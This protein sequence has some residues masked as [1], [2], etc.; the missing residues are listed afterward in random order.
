M[1]R[2]RN[3]QPF[4]PLEVPAVG[5]GTIS[6]PDDLAGSYG[7]VTVQSNA[8]LKLAGGVY[9]FASLAVGTNSHVLA[10]A[11]TQLL[12]G[13]SVSVGSN[14]S[15]APT[16]AGLSAN[17]P[18]LSASMSAMSAGCAALR[19]PAAAMPRPMLPNRVRAGPHSG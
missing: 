12:V 10:L 6:L 5:G 19:T 15:L 13:G 4:P 3:G 14:A 2:L 7:V 8:T 18:S 1:S 11:E 17:A 16:G 9:Q